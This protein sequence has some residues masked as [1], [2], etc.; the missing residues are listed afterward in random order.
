MTNQPVTDSIFRG[1][2]IRDYL[3]AQCESALVERCIDGDWIVLCAREAAHEGKVTKFWVDQ[4][5][6]QSIMEGVEMRVAFPDLVE[7]RSVSSDMADLY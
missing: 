4:Q 2:L 5:Q 7:Q 1:T 6:K 3:C